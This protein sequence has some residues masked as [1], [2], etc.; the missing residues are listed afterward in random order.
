MS[1]LNGPSKLLVYLKKIDLNPSSDFCND[2][3]LYLRVTAD[4]C[5]FSLSSHLCM[6]S[7]IAEC[8]QKKNSKG[9]TW[10]H[11]YLENIT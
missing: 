2:H 10:E 11:F 8:N 6:A 7:K 4:A 3:K 9:R 1:T 5:L